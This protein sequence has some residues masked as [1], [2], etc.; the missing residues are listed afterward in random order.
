MM[1]KGGDRQ[2]HRRR[3]RRRCCRGGAGRAPMMAPAKAM[4]ATSPGTATS[5]GVGR[6][7]NSRQR[8]EVPMRRR[9]ATC[10]SPA[11]PRGRP[12]GQTE[13]HRGLSM[14]RQPGRPRSGPRD[15]DQA[16]A[17]EVDAGADRDDERDDHLN[18]PVPR[19]PPAALSP[20]AFLLRLWIEEGDIRHRGEAK[21]PPPKPAS[22]AQARS[23]PY[24][25]WVETPQ[26]RGQGRQQQQETGDDRPVAPAEAGD[27]EG[28]RGCARWRRRAPAP[29]PARTAGSR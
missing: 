2:P 16:G 10:G 5:A 17:L 18:V 25:C 20:N 19:L 27:G 1:P 6:R 24:D 11:A 13:Q 29:R 12:T 14:A 4:G 15:E 23:T 21:L 8:A 3:G 9:S 7:P 28:S 22:A 26:A